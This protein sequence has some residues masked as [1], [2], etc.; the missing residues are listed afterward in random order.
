MPTTYT[1]QFF[2]L[3]PFAPPP[4]GTALAHVD[5]DLI[6]SNDD[7]DVDRF[8]TDSVDG[9]DVTASYPGDTVT[10]N[11]P[12]VGNITYTGITFYL[13]D[14]REVFT[15]TDGQVL[16][17]GTLVSTTFVTT[18]GALD[19][20]DLGPPCFTPGTLIQTPDGPRLIEKLAIGDLVT[21]V[22]GSAKPIR[23]I[24]SREV[25]G[26]GTF[27]PVRIASGHLGNT[28]D[29]VVSPQHRMLLQ[30]WRPQVTLGQDEVLV[31]AKHLVDDV[32]VVRAPVDRV[33]YFHL[34]FDGHQIIFAEGCPTESF[35]IEGDMATSD[36]ALVAELSAI[37]PEIF[38]KARASDRRPT[39]RP[40][41]RAYEATSLH[42][43][44]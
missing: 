8:D 30:G 3:D 25:E 31:A 40:V 22:D 38:V 35:D 14:G 1:D 6:D 37:F 23:W 9:F 5:L 27:A 39:A 36:R 13:S 16:Q 19:V 32:N 42:A 29:L 41:I 43:A 18:Q 44:G 12:G 20:D 33:T 28:R 24:G 17:D 4:V 34:M 26:Q 15:P 2:V 21:T 7:G 11:V 10:I